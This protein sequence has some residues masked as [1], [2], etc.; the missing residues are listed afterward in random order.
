MAVYLAPFVGDQFFNATGQVLSGGKLFSY[1]AGTTTPQQTW[2]SNSGLVPC[3]NPMIL[4]SAGLMPTEMWFAGG[5]PMKIVVADAANNTLQVLDN[6]TGLNDFSTLSTGSSE[7]FQQGTPTYINATSFSVV[8]NQLAAFP[9]GIRLKL[10]KGTGNVYGTVTSSVY[11]SVTTVTVAL[12][13]GATLD[14]TLS[15]VYTSIQA[16][17]NLSAPGHALTAGGLGYQDLGGGVSVINYDDI[18]ATGS[19]AAGTPTI[20]A[21]GAD[22][23]IP[24]TISGKGTGR[25]NLTLASMV[26]ALMSSSALTGCTIDSTSTGVTQANGTGGTPLATCG[27]VLNELAANPQNWITIQSYNNSTTGHI[28]FA[29]ASGGLF[30]INW[31]QVTTT[32]GGSATVTFDKPYGSGIYF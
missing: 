27:F 29:T 12:D 17:T 24:L 21:V 8:G 22:T 13:A 16:P 14:N 1:L 3:A 15:A 9:A 2:N 30:T 23:N 19:A 18:R 11:S 4:S 6:I 31:G 25:V 28:T 32:A 5:T 10:T 20:A 26:S 7:W